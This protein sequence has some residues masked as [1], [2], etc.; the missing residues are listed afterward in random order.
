V[1][2]GWK[3]LPWQEEAWARVGAAA[4]DGRLG[5]AL[6]LAGPRGVGKR[7]FAEGLT[8]FLLCESSEARPC[9]GCRGCLQLAAGT[10][11]NLFR[12]T[13]AEDR[14]EIPIDDVRALIGGLQLT[15][16]Y[17]KEKVAVIG[18]ADA[19]N[20]HGYNALLKTVEEPPSGAH[21]ILVSERWRALPATLRSRCQM[22]R[23][24]PPA[25][26]MAL[27]WLEQN[28]PQAS[29]RSRP[30]WL[31]IPLAFRAELE[32]EHAEQ[33]S[34]WSQSLRELHAGRTEALKT[35]QGMK[36]EQA[37]SWLEWLLQQGTGWLSQTVRPASR[38]HEDAA[39]P[40]GVSTGDLLGLLDDTLEGLRRL[41]GN[42]QPT[43]IAEWIM[44]RWM[45]RAASRSRR[46]A[47]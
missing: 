38:G 4:R 23:F 18:Q 10:H 47:A 27:K 12:L 39:P 22:L 14:R 33:R 1:S 41:E 26:A 29:E 25:P 40:D 24:A 43:L 17:N 13:L 34:A 36:R 46:R 5:Q 32:P 30:L 9:G 19:L 7:H 2:D 16:H 31:R 3:P 11:P 8:A 44:I 6:L 21:L 45:Q 42:V 37:Q 15:S 20:H 28:F 35:V